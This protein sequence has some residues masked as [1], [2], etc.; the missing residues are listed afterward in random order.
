MDP[1]LKALIRKLWAEWDRLFEAWEWSPLDGPHISKQIERMSDDVAEVLSLY[2][3]F[4]ARPD[5]CPD[6]FWSA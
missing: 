4:P 2:D 5:Y 3:A 1:L 6:S